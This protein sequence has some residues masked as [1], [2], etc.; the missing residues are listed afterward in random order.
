[1]RQESLSKTGPS[2]H[3]EEKL[4]ALM[5]GGARGVARAMDFDAGVHMIR[6]WMAYCLGTT[7]TADG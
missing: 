4:K 1:M 7:S 2:L 6:S 3:F 5:A